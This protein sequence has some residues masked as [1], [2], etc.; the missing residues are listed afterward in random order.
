M[1]N[2]H[3]WQH[4]QYFSKDPS[5]IV[6]RVSGEITV[7][8]VPHNFFLGVQRVDEYSRKKEEGVR[9]L[10][11]EK[12]SE[13]LKQWPV[14]TCALPLTHCSPELDF[15]DNPSAD[16]NIVLLDGHHRVRY[17]PIFGIDVVPAII[18][19]LTQTA[20]AYK[21]DSLA[22]MAQTLATWTEDATYTFSKR[23]SNLGFSYP[24]YFKQGANGLV[25]VKK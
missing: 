21:I 1:L 12:G 16:Y 17:A 10:F 11:K 19:T 25:P 9:K 2:E 3:N 24:I 5:K 4:F 7:A 23:K 18:L 6:E 14:V 15:Y 22:T 8:Q 20:N 13:F